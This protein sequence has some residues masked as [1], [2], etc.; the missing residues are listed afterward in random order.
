MAA[1]RDWAM[2]LPP[3]TP[4]DPEGCHR[5]WVLV[6]TACQAVSGDSILLNF[7]DL[8]HQDI[9]VAKLTWLSLLG[10]GVSSNTFSIGALHLSSGGGGKRV[11]CVLAIFKASTSNGDR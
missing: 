11:V 4:R 10:T 5:G 2:R 9:S 1:E 8:V 6:K 7:L 3:Y